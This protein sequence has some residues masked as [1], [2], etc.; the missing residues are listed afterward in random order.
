MVLVL[1]ATMRYQPYKV[2]LCICIRYPHLGYLYLYFGLYSVFCILS[3]LRGTEAVSPSEHLVLGSSS[4]LSGPH[5]LNSWGKGY[6][7]KFWIGSNK[8]V[9]KQGMPK[10]WH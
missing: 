5:S 10:Y 4:P 9:K 8:A 6:K 3:G 1:L 7:Q 2:V